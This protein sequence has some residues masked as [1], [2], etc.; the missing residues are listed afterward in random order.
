MVLA[1]LAAAFFFF[2]AA[3]CYVGN[4]VTVVA[5]RNGEVIGSYP[6]DHNQRLAFTDDEG[7]RN[8]LVI[9]EGKAYMEEADCPDKL[10]VKQ[11]AIERNGESII[12]LPHKLVIRIAGGEE[13]EVDAVAWIEEGCG[14]EE[15]NG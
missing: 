13:G 14:Y 1:V 4:G 15:K 8:V 5:E 12:C 10:C 6:L 3:L 11:K 2:L 7:K 9:Q